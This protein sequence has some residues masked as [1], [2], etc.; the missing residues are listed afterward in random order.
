MARVHLMEG[1]SGRPLSRDVHLSHTLWNTYDMVTIA[2]FGA[3]LFLTSTLIWI[4]VRVL[5][6]PSNKLRSRY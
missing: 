5:R 6:R 3:L 2:Y 1:V 4:V